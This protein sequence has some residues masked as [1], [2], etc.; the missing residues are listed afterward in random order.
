MIF[1]KLNP[2]HKRL[3]IIN[4][5]LIFTS[6]IICFGIAL[7]VSGVNFVDNQSKISGMFAFVIVLFILV[8]ALMNRIKI[9]FKVKSFGFLIFFLMFVF[10][11]K[12]IDPMQWALGLMMI[13]LLID[14]LVLRPLWLN[15]WYNYYDQ[16]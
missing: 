4:Q 15:L 14:D 10:I 9:L 5:L 11:E 3:F 6:L 7:K 8:L 1:Y 16:N 2:K 13:P 12:V